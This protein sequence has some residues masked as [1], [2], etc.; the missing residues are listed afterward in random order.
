MVIFGQS[1]KISIFSG[2]Y[3][4]IAMLDIFD[5]KSIGIGLKLNNWCSLSYQNH[6]ENISFSIRKK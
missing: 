1:F 2:L 4:L 6:F 5:P 3:V